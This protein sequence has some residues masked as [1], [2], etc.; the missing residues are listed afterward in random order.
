VKKLL[1]GVG[2]LVFTAYFAHSMEAEIE[3]NHKKLCAAALS[4]AL[5]SPKGQEVTVQEIVTIDDIPYVL[6]NVRGGYERTPVSFYHYAIIAQ[7]TKERALNPD[8]GKNITILNRPPH[9]PPSFTLTQKAGVLISS[10]LIKFSRMWH[11]SASGYPTRL[12]KYQSSEKDATP[13][14][15]FYARFRFDD[16]SYRYCPGDVHTWTEKYLLTLD[17]NKL[18]FQESEGWSDPYGFIG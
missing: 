4:Q 6:G 15:E 9:E 14:L 1:V 12:A 16:N 5:E 2:L 7:F 13:T 3:T 17:G 10:N 18:I 8:F 11:Y